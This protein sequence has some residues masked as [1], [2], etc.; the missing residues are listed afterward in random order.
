MKNL[1]LKF[2]LCFLIIIFFVSCTTEV[3]ENIPAISKEDKPVDSYKSITAEE[4]LK[5]IEGNDPYVLID[6]RT[7]EEYSEQRIEGAILI[8][9][10]EIKNR[11]VSEIPDKKTT[12]IVYCRT[13]IR[14]ANAC[15]ELSNLGYT[16]VYDLGG[17]TSW[18]YETVSD[19][20][21]Q[22]ENDSNQTVL[23]YQGHASLMITTIEGKIIY[24]DPYAGE[25]YDIAADL[26]L[27]THQHSDHN[28]VGL[29]KSRN[30]DCIVIT[31]KEAL[32]DGLHQTIQL[33]YLT[34]EAVEAGNKNHNPKEC[35]G[36][37]LTFS[38]GVTLY[39]SGDTSKT[40]QMESLAERNLDYILL[41]CDGVYNMDVKEASECAEI[42]GAR[43]SIPYHMIPGRLFSNEIAEKFEADGRIIVADGEEIILGKK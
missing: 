36:Y 12:I 15:E 25:G 41:C 6:V 35:V 34:I 9:H 14:S 18:P 31:E 1:I 16:N 3:V 23:L 8:P 19:S 5:I 32:K 17:I 4:A 10:T 7:E 40:S 21:E 13:G 33:D 20:L 2:L 22:V 27:V 37:L 39:I 42:I 11:A 30:P 29:I 28:N 38:D 43:H 26:I 24:V